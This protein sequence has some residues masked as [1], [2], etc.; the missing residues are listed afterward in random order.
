MYQK[1]T[2]LNFSYATYLVIV[3]VTNTCHGLV[4]GVTQAGEGQNVTLPSLPS[5]CG[6]TAERRTRDGEDAGSKLACAVWFF[7]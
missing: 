6:A 4:W 3:S 1:W 7:P 5:Q 2:C